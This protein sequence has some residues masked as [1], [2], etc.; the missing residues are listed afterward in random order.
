MKKL[1]KRYNVTLSP[2]IVWKT[3]VYAEQ[4][5][6]SRS[7]LI[8]MLLTDFIKSKYGIILTDDDKDSFDSDQLLLGGE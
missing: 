4:N 2:A 6:L 1:K 3:D 7:E 5:N 8:Q